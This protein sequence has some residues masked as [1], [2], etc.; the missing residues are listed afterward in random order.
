MIWVVGILSAFFIVITTMIILVY[1]CFR[2]YGRSFVVLEFTKENPPPYLDHA[3][4]EA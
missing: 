3:G 4:E 1:L 2:E